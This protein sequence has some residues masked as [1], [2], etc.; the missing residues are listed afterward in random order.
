MGDDEP[1]ENKTPHE[2][3][4]ENIGEHPATSPEN[5]APSEPPPP[6]EVE[7]EVEEEVVPPPP[8]NEATEEGKSP[9]NQEGGGNQKN[10]IQGSHFDI[11]GDMYIGDHPTPKKDSDKQE[12]TDR[13]LLRAPKFEL[14]EQDFNNFRGSPITFIS[15]H[16]IEITTDA[17]NQIIRQEE[18]SGIKLDYRFL[19]SHEELQPRRIFQLFRGANK[20]LL[21]ENYI[22]VI[23]Q[24]NIEILNSVKRVSKGTLG[25]LMRSLE[26]KNIRIFFLCRGGITKASEVFPLEKERCSLWTIDF[27]PPLLTNYGCEE[28]IPIIRKQQEL[29]LWKKDEQLFYEE[30]SNHL[31]EGVDKLADHVDLL[32]SYDPSTSSIRNFLKE[33]VETI[34]HELVLGKSLVNSYVIFAVT[35][36]PKLSLNQLNKLLDILFQEDEITKARISKKGKRTEKK[37]TLKKLWQDFE[38][39]SDFILDECYVRNYFEEDSGREYFDFTEP[40][41]RAKYIT[42]FNAKGRNQLQRFFARIRY[43]LIYFEKGVKGD[44]FNNLTKLSVEMAIKDPEEFGANQLIEFINDCVYLE[45][46]EVSDPNFSIRVIKEIIKKNNVDWLVY[47]VS[48]LAYAMVEAPQL[49]AIVNNLLGQYIAKGHHEIVYKLIRHLHFSDAFDTFEWLRKI[50]NTAKKSVRKKGYELLRDIALDKP[51]EIYDILEHLRHKWAP[52]D[53]RTFSKYSNSNHA[54]YSFV[55]DAPLYIEADS[56]G[57]YPIT[58][59]FFLRSKESDTKLSPQEEAFISLLFSQSTAKSFDEFRVRLLGADAGT[60]PVRYVSILRYWYLIIFGETIVDAPKKEL[61]FNK[62]LSTV[63]ASLSF[64]ELIE[65]YEA[66]SSIEEFLFSRLYQ[67]DSKD[68]KGELQKEKNKEDIQECKARVNQLSHILQKIKKA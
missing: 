3:A 20:I 30:I 60:H 25:N 41:L 16:N 58:Y 57:T 64:D 65:L 50:I 6:S 67:L 63:K 18:Q 47:R 24:G 36:F 56:L 33:K 53:G 42:Y 49:E 68:S 62:I 2:A 9:P 1:K 37:I 19:P 14:P 51:E 26:E 32:A 44:F 54:Y 34:D 23:D 43:S 40:Y 12:P 29:G 10:T 7:V 5:E 38:E 52:D 55:M 59:P 15:C 61:F 22:L 21:D 11:G 46:K 28:L 39:G 35:F 66:F 48:N 13:Y 17:V 4:E 31:N 45:N 27:L 8:S